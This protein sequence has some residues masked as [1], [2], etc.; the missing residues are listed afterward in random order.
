MTASTHWLATASAQA[1]LERG[2][3]AFDAAVAGGFVLHVV[4]P[5]LNGPGGDLVGIFAT[6]STPGTPVVLMGQGPAPAGATIDALSRRGTRAGS[7]CRGPRGGGA[8]LSGRLARTAPRPRHVGA[9]RCPRLRD[10]LR[11]RRASAARPGQRDDRS[12]LSPVHRALAVLR[13]AVDAGG[14]RP[15]GRHDH[16]QSRLCRCPGVAGQHRPRHPR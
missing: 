6:A 8:R 9:V 7:R 13:G 12:R 2:G 16:A 3:N 4:E 10:R 15:R 1:V 14:A 5:H 11:P